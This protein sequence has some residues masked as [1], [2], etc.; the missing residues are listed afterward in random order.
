VSDKVTF[1]TGFGA[2]GREAA[3]WVAKEKG[4][5][6]AQGIEVD[7]RLG[8]AGDHNLQ[9]VASG[10]AQFALIDYAGAVV[11]AGNGRFADFRLVGAVNP[12]TLISLMALD[13]SGITRPKDLEGKRIGQAAGAVPKTLFPTYARLAGIDAKTVTWVESTPQG[14]PA[15]LAAGKVDAIGQFVV[16]KPAIAKVA[17]GR[18]VITLPYS[19]VLTDLYG[20]AVVTTTDLAG[21]NPD[22]ARRFTTA[23]MQGLRYAVDHPQEAA[24]ILHRYQPNTDIPTAAAELELMRAYTVTDQ[25]GLPAGAFD[26]ARVARSVAALESAGLI[27][28]AIDPAS[29]VDFTVMSG[30]DAATAGTIVGAYR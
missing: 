7:I 19:D 17:G 15:L 10:K 8:A 14:L 21:R 5:F 20:N 6:Q 9:L 26:P 11:R 4:F 22:L 16:G 28:Q 3:P 30:P 13:G 27:P 2:F 23:L 29:F 24:Q 1:L 12:Q 18:Q 25:P